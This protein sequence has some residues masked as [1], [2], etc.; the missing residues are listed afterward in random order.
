MIFYGSNSSHLKTKLTRQ[1]PCANCND[2]AKFNVEVYGKYAHLYWIPI[3]PIG[4]TG[5]AVCSNCNTVFE[6]KQMDHNLK[7]EYQNVKE[8]AKTPIK[9]FSALFLIVLIIGGLA[10]SSFLDN[11]N[12]EKY[13][14]NPMVND[15][16]EFK[17]EANY[18]STMKISTISDS[19]YFRFN[20]YETNKKS[21]ISEI[22]IPKNYED[23]EFGYTTEELQGLF[24]DNI[25][26]EVKRN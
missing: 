8:E 7:I 11:K 10:F 21:G 22:D 9:H 17:T 6:P 24:K 13:I 18:Y 12:S 19:I 2:S 1:I 14:A 20:E 15:L 16:Y 25:I 5:G 23:E 3:F 4:K 26:Y